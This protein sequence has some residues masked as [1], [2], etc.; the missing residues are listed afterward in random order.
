[1]TQMSEEEIRKIATERVKSQLPIYDTYTSRM[2]ILYLELEL[3]QLDHRKLFLL[4]C[5]KQTIFQSHD[6]SIIIPNKF[7]LKPVLSIDIF[8]FGYLD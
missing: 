5:L 4:H 6:L 2:Q 3:T 7:Y 8:L 1:M